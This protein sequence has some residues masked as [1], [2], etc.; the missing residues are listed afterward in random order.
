MKPAKKTSNSKKTKL[1]QRE[2]STSIQD[3]FKANAKECAV[4]KTDVRSIYVRAL[5]DRLKCK[6]FQFGMTML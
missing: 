2:T 5:K 1:T 3:Y 4:D 6:L